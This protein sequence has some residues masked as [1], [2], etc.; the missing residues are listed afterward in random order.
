VSHSCEI[1]IDGDTVVRRPRADGGIFPVYDLALQTRVINALRDVPT[2]RPAV[3]EDGAMRMPFVAGAIPNDFTPLDPWLA[4]LPDD[5]SRRRVWESTIDVIS[6]I[7]REP[8]VDGLR[9]GLAADLSY[10]AEYLDWIGDAPSPLRDAFAWCRSNAPLATEPAAVL[11]WGDV[12]F[13]NIVYDGVTLTPKSVLDW[14]MVSAGPREMDIAW[15]TA[16]D[17]VGQELSGLSVPGFGSRSEALT[18][19]GCQ[20]E[21]FD[22]YEIFALVR[23]SAISTKIALLSSKPMFKPGED[24]TLAAATKRIAAWPS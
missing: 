14:D 20:T 16:L 9:V 2:P 3:Y 21:S 4:S 18:R 19:F 13:G 10:W 7:H 12:R 1:E 15:L 5:A 17:A 11:L 22:W 6:A 23:A 8:L 24:P